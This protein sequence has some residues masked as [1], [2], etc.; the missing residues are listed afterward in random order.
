MKHITLSEQEIA[1]QKMHKNTLLRAKHLFDA[2]GFVKIENIFSK[3]VI[4][5]FANAYEK[6]L[7]FNEEAMTLGVGTQ[8]SDKRYIVPIGINAS[9]NDPK[10]YANEMLMPLLQMILG[11]NLILG[12]IG[13]VS[14]LPGALEQHI[15]A[16][17][18]CLFEEDVNLS[19]HLPTY[20]I[21]FAVPLLDIDRLNGP[22]KIWSGSHKT[23]PIEQSMQ[24]YKM[25]LLYGPL[26]SCYFWDYRTFHAGGSNHSEK[27]RSLLYMS[28]T[29][30][31]FKDFLNP[32]LLHIESSE[33]HSL[34]PEHK[35]LFLALQNRCELQKV[36]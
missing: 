33:Y 17:Y 4:E 12:S 3:D 11:K 9:F 35:K 27:I 7:D 16:D 34:L 29:R 14:A 32:E 23:Y 15:H 10:V 6:T 36:N 19:Y 31:W 26:G 21:T 25:E 18:R 2:Q 13:A 5:R 30:C 22:T 28:Y 24:S 20:A 1:E 8:V